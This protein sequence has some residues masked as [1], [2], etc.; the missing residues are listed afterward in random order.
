[1]FRASSL[2]FQDLCGWDLQLKMLQASLSLSLIEGEA[3]PRRFSC[4]QQNPCRVQNL[5]RRPP[6]RRRPGRALEAA[7]TSTSCGS[8]GKF[9]RLAPSLLAGTQ[10]GPQPQSDSSSLPC[11]SFFLTPQVDCSSLSS[12]HPCHRNFWSWD[13]EI[14]RHD[15]F[16][17]SFQGLVPLYLKISRH[18]AETCC[19]FKRL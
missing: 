5:S 8:A 18:L 10:G 19:D 7:V 17:L 6:W 9:L 11:I 16:P 2:T 15:Y 13:L 14:P 1:M 3:K 4:A 12:T